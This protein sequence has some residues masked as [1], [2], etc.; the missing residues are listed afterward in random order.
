LG[1]H[2]QFLFLAEDAGSV[3]QREWWATKLTS[4]RVNKLRR[5]VS[6]NG[7]RWEKALFSDERGTAEGNRKPRCEG[8]IDRIW[9]IITHQSWALLANIPPLPKEVSLSINPSIGII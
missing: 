3:I 4:S 5:L 1:T 9:S 6:P 2:R 7:E 8:R